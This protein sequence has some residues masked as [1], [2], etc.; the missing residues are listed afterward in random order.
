[1]IKKGLFG[2]NKKQ[3]QE[4][5]DNYEDIINIQKK[6][7]EYLKQDNAELKNTLFEIS[8]ELA[9]SDMVKTKRR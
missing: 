2:Y 4:M 6:D 8:T 9:Q 7:I 5:I 3:V 1:M